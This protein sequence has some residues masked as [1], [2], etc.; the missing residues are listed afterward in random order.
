MHVDAAA[1]PRT[2][3]LTRPRA[4]HSPGEALNLDLSEF[5]SQLYVIIL[6]LSLASDIE[7]APGPSSTA[8]A[9]TTTTTSA[10]APG[11]RAARAPSTADLLFRALTLV[12][13][14][15][16]LG[17]SAPPWRSAAFAKR[18][19]GAALH[20]PP[21]TALRALDFVG[22][23]VAKDPKLEAL[24]A[25]DDRAANGV[26]RAEIDDPQLSHAFGSAFWELFA[27][28][29]DHWDARVRAEAGKLLEATRH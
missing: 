29:R 17:A 8:A 14:P 15:R 4:L 10:G 9:A 2:E 3:Q 21:A 25:T 23:L 19:L 22:G 18:L 28:L 26:Y 16:S 1:P 12:F 24:L 11:S 13:S 5:I 6:P 27:L 7:A 20:W